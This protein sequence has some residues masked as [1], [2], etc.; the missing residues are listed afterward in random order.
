MLM[1]TS[2]IIIK[3]HHL[4]LKM[5]FDVTIKCTI[6]DLDFCMTKLT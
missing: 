1:M 3:Y 4:D 5:I 2:K 6:L